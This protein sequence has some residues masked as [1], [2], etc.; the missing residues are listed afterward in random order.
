MNYELN[1]ILGAT[2]SGEWY[3]KLITDVA[4]DDEPLAN[5]DAVLSRLDLGSPEDP[6]ERA[7]VDSAFIAARKAIENV[8]H[9]PIGV[10][11]FEMG[12]SKFPYLW[13]LELRKSPLV[14]IKTIKYTKDDGTT[15][16]WYDSTASPVVDPGAFTIET[17]SDPG[18]IFMKSLGAW[19]T[20]ILQ[21]GFPVKI[22]FTAGIDPIP[23]DLMQAMRYAF[24]QF[25]ENRE[26]VTDGRVN[27]PFEVPKTLEWLCEK[28]EYKTYI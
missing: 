1:K 26:P 18:A 16:T 8:I 11:E 23:D 17:S 28:Y 6:Q 20:G 5:D 19:P 12:L 10:Q 14:A 25:Y 3:V 7:Y 21:N 4:P 24:A 15:V 13:V 27:Q 22:R 9:R 2:A